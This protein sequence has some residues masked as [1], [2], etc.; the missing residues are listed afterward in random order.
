MYFPSGHFPPPMHCN[1]SI[2]SSP[3]PKYPKYQYFGILHLL[4]QPKQKKYCR[5]FSASVFGGGLKMEKHGMMCPASCTCKYTVVHIH[6]GESVGWWRH[7]QQQ[8]PA[9]FCD[10]KHR[11]TGR[12]H[13]LSPKGW[14]QWAE[15]HPGTYLGA[16]QQCFPA[17]PTPSSPFACECLIGTS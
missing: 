5:F 11:A 16:S 3:I 17:N 2:R 12:T 4:I 8:I 9:N 15:F 1:L 14:T 6:P 10:P 7:H 13:R